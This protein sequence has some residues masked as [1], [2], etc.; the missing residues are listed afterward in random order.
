MSARAARGGLGG[1]LYAGGRLQPCDCPGDQDRG[2]ALVHTACGRSESKHL[3]PTPAGHAEGCSV[4]ALCWPGSPRQAGC[5]PVSCDS[6]PSG[7]ATQRWVGV[8]GTGSPLPTPSP[9]L[10]LGHPEDPARPVRR[11]LA[12][13]VG[14]SA[15]V[16]PSPSARGWGGSGGSLRATR[17]LTGSQVGG[18]ARSWLQRRFSRRGKQR[19]PGPEVDGIPLKIWKTP[20]RLQRVLCGHRPR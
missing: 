7:L 2:M 14:F 1:A 3:R 8:L 16:A 6:G 20:A 5:G 17:H 15:P 13:S 12:R 18:S 11:S 19:G 10:P 4:I 9:T